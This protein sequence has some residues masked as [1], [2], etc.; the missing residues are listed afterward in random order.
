MDRNR[1]T[2][3]TPPVFPERMTERYRSLVPDPQALTEALLQPP[4]RSFR[5]NH[6]KTD[7][8]TARARIEAYGCR[9]VPV[10]W[11]D[12]A[13]II[14]R[15]PAD[16]PRPEPL[17]L[18][19]VLGHIH[20]QELASML[21]PL[22]I[23]SELTTA[24]RV[25]D[26][27][28]A[29]GSKTTLMAALMA[30]KGTIIANDKQFGRVRALK[31]NLERQGVLNTLITNHDLRKWPPDQLFPLILLDAPCSS[32]GTIRKNPHLL[33]RWKETLYEGHSSLQQQLLLR[34]FDLLTPGGLLL[35]ATCSLAPEENEGV[36]D[37]LLR[38][39][40]QASLEPIHVDRITFSPGIAEFESARYDPR[41]TA[42]ARVWPHVHDTDGFFMARIRKS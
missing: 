8:A 5:V 3:N 30:N 34:A 7:P 40:P 2:N 25:L 35:Y 29:P 42:C 6:L 36:V 13:F 4:R 15:Y 28:A 33:A 32:E 22:A 12:D 21:P 23:R 27:C 18:E 41:V 24:E 19:Q 10:P 20:M 31:F 1:T 26:A 17:V 14:D 9:L 38:R 16:S 39:R 37:I 11:Y